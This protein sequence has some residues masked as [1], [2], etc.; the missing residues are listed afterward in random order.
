[1]L[2]VT[3]VCPCSIAVSSGVAPTEPHSWV[4]T[5]APAER[6]KLTARALPLWAAGGIRKGV[7]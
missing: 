7:K 5:L 4:C 1:M 3:S 6:S 2:K